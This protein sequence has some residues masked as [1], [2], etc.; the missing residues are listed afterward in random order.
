M[1]IIMHAIYMHDAYVFPIAH[2]AN[3]VSVNIKRQAI[4]SL[5]ML[6]LLFLIGLVLSPSPRFYV[7]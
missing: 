2:T 1:Y 6:Q 5:M 3:M 4:V 7:R